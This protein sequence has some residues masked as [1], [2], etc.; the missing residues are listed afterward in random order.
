MVK[1]WRSYILSGMLILSIALTACSGGGK[2]EQKGKEND[3]ASS[4]GEE[5]AS[6]L[7][8]PIVKDGSVTLTYSG[9]DNNYAP[10]SYAQN[11][12]V[13]QEIEKRTG[14]KI[15]WEVL[16]TAQYSTT[17]QTRLAASQD[18]PDIFMIPNS[19]SVLKYGQEEILMPLNDLIAKHAPNTRKMFEKWP[20]LKKLYTQP[21]GKIYGISTVVIGGAEVELRSLMVRKDWLQK[22]GMKEPSTLDEW[23]QL[24]KAFK[25]KD[26]NG[27]GQA[28]EIPFVAPT[29][30]TY[31]MFAYPFG[32]HYHMSSGWW[33]GEDGKVK[34]EI[35]EPAFK[36]YLTYLN[37]LYA[38]GLI[39]PEIVAGNDA[40]LNS[41]ISKNVV[42]ASCHNSTVIATWD[43]L[44]STAGVKDGEY[45]AVLPPKSP[46]G[47]VI[48]EKKSPLASWFGISKKSKNA[49]VAMKWL[50]YVWASEEGNILT[51]FGIEGKSYTMKEGKPQL[52][53]WVMKNPDNLDMGSAL[54]TLGAFPTLPYVQ[55]RELMLQLNPPKGQAYF[56]KAKEY[57]IDPFPKL[58]GTMEENEK[59]TSIMADVN[60]LVSEKI[61]KFIMGVDSMDKFDNFV[62]QVKSMG[63]DEVIKI[64]Q[65][66]YERYMNVK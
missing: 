59:M 40:K 28:D 36:E 46:D 20:Q 60:T 33:A 38:E 45:A 63:I 3:N 57:T 14:V 55:T 35:I 30:G 27:N 24:L 62:K 51:N 1:K 18:I 42:G 61:Q 58:T 15:K 49:E 32:L 4:A 56:E 2:G 64:K 5:V 53:D 16:P 31:G 39:H 11:L 41:L 44:L 12:P 66:Q 47:K 29:M 7:E 37:K 6:V 26:M 10:A 17:M 43:S 34:Y 8:L 54:R 22:V 19:D 21:D 48:L 9:N 50:D 13:W 52:T 65:A 23:Y 25:E